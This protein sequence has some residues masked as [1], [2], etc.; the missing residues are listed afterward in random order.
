[1][2]YSPPTR[3]EEELINDLLRKRNQHVVGEIQSQL[4]QTDNIMVP[5]G[6]AHMPG[7]AREIQKAGF[8]LDETREYPLIQ[9][10][11]KGTVRNGT[12]S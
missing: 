3:L 7:I 4:L 12:G 5:W 1:M 6:A 9:F 11:W 10:R 2:H 8:R